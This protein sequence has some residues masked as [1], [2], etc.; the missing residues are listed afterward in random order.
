[1]KFGLD[2][3]SI[4]EIRS[5]FNR[6]PGVEKVLIY[7]SRAMGNYR[8]GSDIDLAIVG[9]QL[10]QRDIRK[11]GAELDKLE[12]LYSFDVLLYDELK[13][14]ELKDHIDRMGQEIYRAEIKQS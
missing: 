4:E 13:D 3:N 2:E 9:G 5:V 14:A 1:M 11:I 10:T 7:G 6:F 12:M 8:P